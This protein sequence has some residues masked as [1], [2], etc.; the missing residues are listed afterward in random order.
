MVADLAVDLEAA[1]AAD[2]V[3]ATAEEVADLVD[4]ITIIII[5][6]DRIT[7][8][9]GFSVLVFTAAVAVLVDCWAL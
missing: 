2:L 1:V 7:V 3:A 4:L 6:T 8:A 9:V 5:I